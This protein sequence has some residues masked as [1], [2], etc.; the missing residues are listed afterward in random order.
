MTEVALAASA[1]VMEATVA[2]GEVV[3][4]G[5]GSLIRIVPQLD[6]NRKSSTSFRTEFAGTDSATRILP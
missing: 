5:T 2:T 6:G 3:V 4:M 1:E